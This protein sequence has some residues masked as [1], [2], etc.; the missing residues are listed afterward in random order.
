MKE[1][2]TPYAFLTPLHNPAYPSQLSFAIASPHAKRRVSERFENQQVEHQADGSAVV[3]A[4][5]RS[6]FRIMQEL[7]RYGEHAE[8]LEPA[9]LREKMAET[10]RKMARVYGDEI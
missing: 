5:D 6:G 2:P 8:L 9:W 10:A 7:L 3:Q 1:Y 4:E